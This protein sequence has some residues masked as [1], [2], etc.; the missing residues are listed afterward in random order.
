[1]PTVL[2]V[3]PTTTYRAA[4]FVDAARRLGV[5]LVVA[6]EQPIP[7]LPPSRV[8]QIDCS[9]PIESAVNIENWALQHPLDA[10]VAADDQGLEAAALAAN[11]LG[12]PHHSMAGVTASLDKSQTRRLLAQAE[13]PQPEWRLARSE[14]E[15]VA[16]TEALG[17]PV[18]VKPL[19]LSASQGVIKVDDPSTVVQTVRRV[20]QIIQAAGKGSEAPLLIERFIPG[21][22]VAV[23]AMASKGVIEILAVFDKPDQPDGPYFEETIYVT[24]S[25]LAPVAL[26]EVERVTA[27]GAAA[28][29]LGQ[30]PI[31]AELRIEAGKVHLI[32][33]AARSIG[34]ACSRSLD[35]GFA[36]TSLEML[37]LREALGIRRPL[38]SLPGASGVMMIPIPGHGILRGVD[39]IQECLDVAGITG[40]EIS[41][42]VGGAVVPLPEGNRYLGFLFARADSSDGVTDALRSGHA[43]LRFHID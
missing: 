38:P 16:A 28:L 10:I 3:L 19:T 8:V 11:R 4:D 6:S 17:A 2:V 36:G 14:D 33:M 31:H 37:I 5:E 15:A 30:G 1:M 26:G 41:I 9:Q 32:E 24:P 18:V 40:H 35:F 42:P 12:L 13:V 43:A 39:G 21:P 7:S 23:E 25:S 22:E 20:R 27:L 34:G 29:G